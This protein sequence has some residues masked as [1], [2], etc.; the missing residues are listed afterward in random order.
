MNAW[1]LPPLLRLATALHQRH[2]DVSV[3]AR[4]GPS[5]AD[6]D[7]IATV[8][9]VLVQTD[10]GTVAFLPR[11]DLHQPILDLLRS[12]CKSSREIED[13]L[14]KRFGI[15][16]ATRTTLLRSG[17]PAWRNHVAWALGDLVEHKRGNRG[18][19]KIKRVKG[20][21]DG[22]GGWMGVYCLMS[23]TKRQDD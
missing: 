16:D 2:G 4:R 1:G 22:D 8:D 5:D 19:G 23:E 10:V 14:A 20:K 11:P 3:P 17:C 15:T 21:S 18:M 12:G 13:Y 9:S 7:D 6:L